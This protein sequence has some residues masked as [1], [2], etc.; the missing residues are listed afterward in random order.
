MKRRYRSISQINPFLLNLFWVMVFCFS[1]RNPKTQVQP[2]C[3][4]NVRQNRSKFIGYKYSSLELEPVLGYSQKSNM[5]SSAKKVWL[6]CCIFSFMNKKI[7]GRRRWN[8]SAMVALQARC[9]STGEGE[10]WFLSQ[11]LHITRGMP[12]SISLTFKNGLR[13]EAVKTTC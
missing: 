6:Q 7:Q 3:C 4:S 1:D 8:S 10:G 5:L 12:S 11:A 9:S 13:A 2:L